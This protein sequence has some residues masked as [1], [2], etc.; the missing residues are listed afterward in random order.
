M[1]TL[2][3]I[4]RAIS[5]IRL[6]AAS[7][8]TGD[9]RGVE[10]ALH[11]GGQAMAP[12]ESL[13]P[14]TPVELQVRNGSGEEREVW[15]F[16]IDADYGIQELFPRGRPAL[17][18]PDESMPSPLP[19]T[20]TD[21]TLGTE[22][23]LTLVVPAGSGSL[24][25]L[26]QPPLRTRGVQTRDLARALQNLMFGTRG[27]S[28]R[29]NRGGDVRVGLRSW[30]TTWGAI[31]PPAA[32]PREPL[33][34]PAARAATRSAGPLPDPWALRNVAAL[35]D[36]ATGRADVLLG[37]GGRP[38]IMLFDLDGGADV[39]DAALAQLADP[40]TFDAELALVFE[41]GRRIA[42]YDSDDDGTFDLAL[43]DDDDDALAD[44]ELT[45]TAGSWIASASTGRPW[46]RVSNLESL[47]RGRDQR[48]EN[49]ALARVAAV[50][51]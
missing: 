45:L 15:V 8:A 2:L 11:R 24:T 26:G 51:R 49:R 9:V 50:L 1:V 28:V 3:Q 37:G 30:Q 48:F 10:A 44:G 19:F 41:A 17:L 27:V 29:V 22:H 6:A 31:K 33:P 42:Y 32:W 21:S 20:A 23:L 34:L 35:R 25:W 14:S 12:G 43:I 40:R 47:L 18:A 46:L 16:L 4:H 36:P 38:E 13:Q 7:A 39:A 5:L